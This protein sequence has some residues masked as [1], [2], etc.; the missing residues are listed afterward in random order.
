MK[1]LKS[2]IILLLIVLIGQSV[3]AQKPAGAAS[4]RKSSAAAKPSVAQKTSQLSLTNKQ[5]F[6]RSIGGIAIIATDCGRGR[7][8]QGSGFI[9]GDEY[10]ATNRHVVECGNKTALKL[11][12]S[13]EIFDVAGVFFH[14]TKDLAIL[15]V[16]K[17]DGKDITLPLAPKN[18]LK[19]NDPV[20]VLGSPRGIEGY[21]SDGNVNSIRAEQFYFDA[22]VAP[23]SSGSP[24]FDAQGRV[25]GVETTG[26]ELAATTI[27][28]AILISEVT[29]LLPSVRKGSVANVVDKRAAR[30]REVEDRNEP[31]VGRAP[32]AIG[33]LIGALLG[34]GSSA[35]SASPVSPSPSAPA[36]PPPSGSIYAPRVAPE[37][38][39]NELIDSAERNRSRSPQQ[40]I[41]AANK[42]LS[43][44]PKEAP[45]REPFASRAHG[46][47]VESLVRQ[48]QSEQ[49]VL[50]VLTAWKAGDSVRINVKQIRENKDFRNDNPNSWKNFVGGT[51]TMGNKITVYKQDSASVGVSFPDQSFTARDED[52]VKAEYGSGSKRLS[53]VIKFPN[54]GKEF[55]KDFQFYPPEAAWSSGSFSYGM[56]KQVDCGSCSD[57]LFVLIKA[58]NEFLRLEKLAAPTPR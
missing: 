47:I 18:S 49:A 20:F 38:S 54:Q 37:P 9:I 26:T 33:I 45:S 2:T 53:L 6:S 10:V 16:P 4:R 5:I 31:S 48:S 41:E 14:P 57:V 34:I 39:L 55:K 29:D 3:S 51:I 46:V 25:V 11:L 13:Q 7:T 36:S 42:V 40:S 56:L 22:K 19:K 23:G 50:H 8:S 27:G 52:V 44:L 24:V 35:P 28:G 15:R 21:F 1:Q 30:P 58:S 12:A 43:L 17:L 32:S